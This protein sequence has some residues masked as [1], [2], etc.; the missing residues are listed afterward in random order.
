MNYKFIMKI[1]DIFQKSNLGELEIEMDK[2]KLRMKLSKSN[3]QGQV[4]VQPTTPIQVQTTNQPII[5]EKKEETEEDKK[6]YHVIKS[7]LVG[8]FYRAPSPGAEP[9]VK[10]GDFVKKG[11]VLCIVEAMKV[12]NEIE[13]DVDGIVEKILVENGKPV[14]YGQELFWIKVSS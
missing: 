9:F 14:E 1:I 8:T 12:M 10:E 13:S 4:I 3:T 7:P 11:Q 6:N 2:P 5:Q